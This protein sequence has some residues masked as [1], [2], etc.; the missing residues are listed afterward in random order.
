[1]TPFIACLLWVV[2]RKTSVPADY[3]R[4]R[5]ERDYQ[6]VYQQ[7]HG[8]DVE[9]PV[10]KGRVDWIGVIDGETVAAEFDFANKYRQAIG[11]ALDYAAQ[12]GYRP[13]IILIMKS[14]KDAEYLKLLQN[15]V[16][17]HRLPIVV[18][19]VP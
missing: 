7:Y 6:R 19:T 8:G 1:V 11:Q 17:H 4:C 9:R 18:R 12:T 10:S 5:Y 15:A 3:S 2:L 13:A 14:A 16:N